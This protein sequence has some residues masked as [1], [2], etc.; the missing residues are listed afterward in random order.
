MINRAELAEQIRINK[1]K[2]ALQAAKDQA[3]EERL[4]RKLQEFYGLQKQREQNAEAPK[5]EWS[6]VGTYITKYLC[7]HNFISV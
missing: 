4:E 6:R 2:K 5:E 3:E 1:K 7:I